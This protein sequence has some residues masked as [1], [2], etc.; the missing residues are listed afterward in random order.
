MEDISK[1]DHLRARGRRVLLAVAR[2]CV[3]HAW[4]YPQL[5]LCRPRHHLACHFRLNRQN[6]MGKHFKQQKNKTKQK[7]LA[8]FQPM[9]RSVFILF[10]L[11]FCCHRFAVSKS[12]GHHF[13]FFPLCYYTVRAGKKVVDCFIYFPGK[14]KKSNRGSSVCSI[15]LSVQRRNPC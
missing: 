15:N 11:F 10:F 12:V 1:E 14:K 2:L 7:K 13:P 8:I 3:D 4:W 5:L 9:V 6:Q